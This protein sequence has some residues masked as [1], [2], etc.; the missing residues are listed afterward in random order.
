[1]LRHQLIFGLFKNYQKIFLS[2]NFGLK[3]QNLGQKPSFWKNFK[4]GKIKLLGSYNLFC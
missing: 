3:M 4:N 2:E 1:M